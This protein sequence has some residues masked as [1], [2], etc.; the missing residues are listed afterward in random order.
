MEMLVHSRKTE[1]LV[2]VLLLQISS[3]S[4]ATERNHLLP[5]DLEA[6]ERP[7]QTIVETLYFVSFFYHLAMYLSNG[8]SGQNVS[9]RG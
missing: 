1:A 5:T 2:V 3:V 6:Q 7:W 9:D 8:S 4:R